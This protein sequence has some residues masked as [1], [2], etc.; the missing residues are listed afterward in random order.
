MWWRRRSPAGLTRIRLKVGDP[1]KADDVVATIVPSPAPLLDP[2]SR[3][4][5]E[6][7]LGAA[8]AAART[9]QGH[10]RADAG[11]GRPGQE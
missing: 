4:E 9:H 8:E 5:A 6:E 1:V 3:R 7:R 10:G 2:R 11:A